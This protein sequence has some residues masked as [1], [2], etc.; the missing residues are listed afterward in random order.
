MKKTMNKKLMIE[1]HGGEFYTPS[2]HSEGL[3]FEVSSVTQCWVMWRILEEH[4]QFYKS[5]SSHTR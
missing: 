5:F 2:F 3:R 1:Y 4:P